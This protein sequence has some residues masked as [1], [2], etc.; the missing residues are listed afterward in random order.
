MSAEIVGGYHFGVDVDGVF[1]G[2]ILYKDENGNL[3]WYEGLAEKYAPQQ[4]TQT[5]SYEHVP[6]DVD[7]PLAA[8]KWSGSGTN[9]VRVAEGNDQLAK[10]SYSRG[11]NLSYDKKFMLAHRVETAL[12]TDN[13]AIDATP[14]VF[15]HSPS[16]GL[17]MGAG[18][19]I[20]QFDLPTQQWALRSSTASGV[21]IKSFR[22]YNDALVAASGSGYDYYT[23]GDG[24]S[25]TAFTTDDENAD[26]FE[27]RSNILW[28]INGQ[29][30]KNST[31]PTITG[32]SGSD[33]LGHTSMTPA[34]FL[35]ADGSLYGFYKEGIFEYTGS[36]VNE[37]WR[38]PLVRANNGHH[39]FLAGDGFIYVP[40]GNYLMKVEPGTFSIEGVFPLTEQ[41]TSPEITGT[42][43]AQTGDE[44]HLYVAVTNG[45]GNNYIMKGDVTTNKWDTWVYMGT[46]VVTSLIWVPEG[47]AHATNPCLMVGTSTPTAGFIILPRAG[48][49]PDTDSNCRFETT[50]TVYWANWDWGALAFP[51][52]LN[53]GDIAGTGLTASNTVALKYEIDNSGSL[54][55]ILTASDS[56]HSN[57]AISTKVEFNELRP[58]VTLTSGSPYSTP[59]VTGFA[60]HATLNP[61]RKRQWRA[62]IVIANDLPMTDGQVD[63]KQDA[64]WIK[65]MLD[66]AVQT[67]C[68]LYDRRGNTAF[69]ILRDAQ[70]QGIRPVTLGGEERDVEVVELLMV[71]VTPLSG[72]SQAF[73]YEED[74]WEL[75]KVWSS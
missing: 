20:Y 37:L 73:I 57:A 55:T 60:V 31:D 62:K 40:Y 5:F 63:T 28:K 4:R 44:R 56:G 32:W 2:F 54:V 50:G 42:F 41:L 33:K 24:S 26:F 7:T 51:K 39:P 34:G 8:E 67:R 35:Q 49:T 47:V 74:A 10:Y 53:E 71:E 36:A 61:P 19:Y 3:A 23:S 21:T 59:V 15:Y 13:T 25:W 29:A 70:G 16:Y 48:F 18:Q 30:I 75:G 1:V 46:T 72:T 66:Q 12:Q 22:E 68:T 58:A 14:L 69:V 43:T 17:F 38:A 45:E 6:P 11:V 27:T 65:D 52:F 64:R 9:R